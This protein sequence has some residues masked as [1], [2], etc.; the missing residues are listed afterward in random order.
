MD[1]RGPQVT[2]ATDTRWQILHQPYLLGDPEEDNGNP[3]STHSQYFLPGGILW[4]EE[5]SGL[6]SW[7]HEDLEPTE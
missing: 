3:T 6:Q 2:D 7:G 1:P 4:V 5:P